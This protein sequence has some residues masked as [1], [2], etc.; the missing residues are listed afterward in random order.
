[1]DSIDALGL[2]GTGARPAPDGGTADELTALYRR[3]ALGLVRLAVVMLGDRGA[4]EDV[5]QEAFL[6]LH[7]RW[8]SLA[9]PSRVMAYL[10]TSVLNGCRTTLHR[11]RR[12]D[13]AAVRAMAADAPIPLDGADAWAPLGEEH[14]EVLNAIKRLPDR[15]REAVVLRFYL[16]MSE[17][18]IARAMQISRGTVKSATFRGMAALGRMLGEEG[19]Q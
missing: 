16:D 9:D 4:A 11:Q 10:R 14:R 7:L 15:Q 3:H 1:M 19:S 5:V 6:G 17:E 12:R 2:P 8:G 18:E 13:N